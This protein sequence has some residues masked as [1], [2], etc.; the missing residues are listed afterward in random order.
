MNLK[1]S[2]LVG[3]IQITI[4]YVEQYLKRFIIISGKLRLVHVFTGQMQLLIS[5]IR[6]TCTFPGFFKFDHCAISMLDI[7]DVLYDKQF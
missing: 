2:W 1:R 7:R 5:T 3:F 4:M 6:F